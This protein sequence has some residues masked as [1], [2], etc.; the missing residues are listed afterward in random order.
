MNGNSVTNLTVL[1]TSNGIFP[2]PQTFQ[3]YHTHEV[4]FYKSN[5]KWLGFALGAV[6]L[7]L[8]ALSTILLGSRDI[9]RTVTSS[10]VETFQVFPPEVVRS[11]CDQTLT[12]GIEQKIFSSVLEI[13]ECSTSPTIALSI[14]ESASRLRRPDF[15]AVWGKRVMPC[16]EL[17]RCQTVLKAPFKNYRFQSFLEK[18]LLLTSFQGADHCGVTEGGRA[19]PA[20]LAMQCRE[21]RDALRI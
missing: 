16:S 13:L 10:P 21:T 14:R 8:L 1:S 12:S 4:M 20:H 15:K 18:R 2:Q 3:A 5:Y 19:V 9:S 17:Y 7:R 11:T 6:L